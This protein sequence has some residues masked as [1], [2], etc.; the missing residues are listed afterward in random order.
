MSDLQFG[1]LVIGAVVVAGVAVFNWWQERQLRR[2]LEQ[3]FGG[4]RG[5]VLAET[6]PAPKVPTVQPDERREPQLVEAG[7]LPEVAE[8]T[9]VPMQPADETTPRDPEAVPEAPWIDAMIDYVVSMQSE[10]AITAAALQEFLASPACSGKPCRAGGWTDGGGWEDLSRVA[11]GRYSNIC[12][13]IQLVN[14]AGAVN[15][16]QLAAFCDGLKG[17]AARYGAE[18]QSPD[19]Q[20]AIERARAL[21]KFCADVDVAIGVNVIAQSGMVF[22]GNA[23]REK[24]LAAGLTLEPGGMFTYSDDGGNVLFSMDNHEPAPFIPEQLNHLTT[25]GITLLLDVPRVKEGAVA[26]ETML[27]RAAQLGQALGGR[28]VDDNRVPLNDAG[29]LAIRRQL[30]EIASTMVRHDVAPGGAR[31]LRLFA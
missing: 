5:D 8:T 9:D 20:A 4:E 6:P 28:L 12:V 16:A 23:I 11:S 24:A 18:L 30:E 2:R 7:S 1:L 29:M 14:R 25:T 31:A 17:I 13:S 3:A 22:A 21:D 15:P 19:V 26:L 10:Q 27:D